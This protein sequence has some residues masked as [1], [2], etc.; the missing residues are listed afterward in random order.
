M[1]NEQK[2]Y[3][4]EVTDPRSVVPTKFQNAPRLADLNGKTICEWISWRQQ[5][6][7]ADK[8]GQAKTLTG[9]WR[10]QDTFPVIRELLKKRYPDI[11]IVPG[12]ELPC[13]EDFG[14]GFERQRSQQDKLDDVTKAMKEKGCDAVLLGN[15]S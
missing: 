3:T 11:K 10:E 12:E 9:H 14:T 6:S 5:F 13:F 15:G 8:P 4:L 7:G 2:G 1:E